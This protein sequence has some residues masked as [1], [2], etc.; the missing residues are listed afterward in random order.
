M[1][2]SSP[3]SAEAYAIPLIERMLDEGPERATG[4]RDERR[5]QEILREEF[6]EL[7]L[8]QDEGDGG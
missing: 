6:R 2:S 1:N 8:D 4:N 3:K 7:R 5:V